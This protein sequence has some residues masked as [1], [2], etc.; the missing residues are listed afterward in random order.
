[1]TKRPN[2]P[3]NTSATF[4]RVSRKKV[5]V[6]ALAAL[7]ALGCVALTPQEIVRRDSDA[8]R[9]LE[10]DGHAV[11]IETWGMDSD[12]VDSSA[13]VEALLLVHGFGGSTYSWH[14]IAPR[15]SENYPTVAVDLYGFGWTERPR[16]RAAYSRSS[17]LELL[18]GVLDGLGIERAHVVGH[19]YGGG[20][21]ATLA[22]R[23][24]ER[25]ASL[26]LLDPTAPD[27]STRK[28]RPFAAVPGLAWLFIRGLA[29]RE[30]FVEHALR[31]AQHDPSTVAEND[32]DAY[33]A[34]L[35]VEGAP[36]AYRGL[37]RPPRGDDER[38]P[39][40]LE[41]I[42][43]PALVLWGEDD[44]LIPVE[45]GRAGTAGLPHSRFVVVPNCGHAPMEERP[46]VVLGH[47]L[48][49]L[50]EVARRESGAEGG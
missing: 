34:R 3:P 44:P 35:R 47:V 18:V 46:D 4:P 38:R 1:M 2:S 9:F 41:E 21:A 25:V 13:P 24:P 40:P 27:W 30:R 19:S 29:L 26:V 32:V 48:P 22:H 28:R 14:K 12:R 31:H 23:R 45:K 42:L 16:R 6:L 39:V 8:G 49:F 33:L 5:L 15:L 50:A 10:I 36:R 7:S 43:Q 11:H 17:Q 37:T 20:L